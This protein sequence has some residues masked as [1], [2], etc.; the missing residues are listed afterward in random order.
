MAKEFYT[1][2][3]IE[4]LARH[5]VSTLEVHDEVYLTDYA[6][7]KAE[8]LGIT[9][10]REHLTP[11][12]APIRPYIASESPSVKAVPSQPAPRRDDLH[13]QV[14]SAVVKRLGDS[15][16]PE[17]LDSIIRRVLDNLG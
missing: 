10:V 12:S 14:R 8:R 2:R 17:L 4:E 16:D 1:E 15:Y 5:G 11:A 6:R 13:E 9:L 3:D 7:E